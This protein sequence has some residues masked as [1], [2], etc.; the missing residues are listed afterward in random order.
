MPAGHDF[1]ALLMGAL[2]GEL[3]AVEESRL[4]AHLAAHPA[5]QQIFHDLTR[6]REAIRTGVAAAVV[7]PPQAISALLLQE[8]ARRAPKST[9]ASRAAA[10][11][12][13]WMKWLSSLLAHPGLAAAAMLTVVVGVAGTMYL[14][15]GTKFAES[16]EAAGSSAAA[17]PAEAPAAAT[18][19]TAPTAPIGAAQGDG[20]VA[21]AVPASPSPDLAAQPPN[22]ADPASA[23]LQIADR[24]EQR[25]SYSVGLDTV[26][27][28]EGRGGSAGKNERAA[29]V[30]SAATPA[31][32]PAKREYIE[33]KPVDDVKLKD[34]DDASELAEAARPSKESARRRSVED[35]PVLADEELAAAPTPP[36]APLAAP[37]AQSGETVPPTEKASAS[38]PGA[39][40]RAASPPANAVSGAARP[41]PV[42]IAP[43]TPAASSKADAAPPKPTPSAAPKLSSSAPT[44]SADAVAPA[45]AAPADK[46]SAVDEAWAKSEHARLL[47]SAKANQCS[48]AASIAGAIALRAPRYYQDHVA[49]D[50]KLR[51]CQ[52]AIRDQ[53]NLQSE[54]SKRRKSPARASEAAPAA[55]K[56]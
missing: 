21:T 24:L 47:R 12:G 4:Q 36:P 26:A 35:A 33:A 56:K 49:A 44:S 2:Y 40:A 34:F 53:L 38:R 6:I 27:S 17:P 41:A 54:Q 37:R 55:N 9:L 5:D 43:T 10:E 13:R 46:K 11:P 16:T 42:A 45:D 14:R 39:V 29:G 15:G 51:V 50:P 48:E 23:Q 8:A 25:E 31:A 30:R 32:K 22:G 1:D 19:A 3:S 18:A 7:E 20:S 28:D 52:A